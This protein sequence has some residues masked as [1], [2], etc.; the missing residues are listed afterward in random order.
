[1]VPKWD[2]KVAELSSHFSESTT[3]ESACFEIASNIHDSSSFSIA[4]KDPHLS[5]KNIR[6]AGFITQD[7]NNMDVLNAAALSFYR[8]LQ[9]ICIS[10]QTCLHCNNTKVFTHES[11]FSV[12]RGTNCFHNALGLLWHVWTAFANQ[13]KKLQKLPKKSPQILRLWHMWH[14]WHIWNI[15][16]LQWMAQYTKHVRSFGLPCRAHFQLQLPNHEGACTH[17]LHVLHRWRPNYHHAS[18]RHPSV[19]HSTLPQKSNS[20]LLQQNTMMTDL[21]S[22]RTSKLHLWDLFC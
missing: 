16:L 7:T 5:L 13:T 18:S 12:F 4:T 20:R 19:F 14:M 9:H 6:C 22:N 1:M 15:W 17:P 21:I 11:K 2:T 10:L 3:T 8:H